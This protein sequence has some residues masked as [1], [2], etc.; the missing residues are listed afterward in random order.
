MQ[1][2]NKDNGKAIAKARQDDESSEE[3]SE[4]VCDTCVCPHIVAGHAFS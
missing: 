1:Q 4:A 3:H 2:A